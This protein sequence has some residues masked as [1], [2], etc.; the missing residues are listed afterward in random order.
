MKE[1][2][3][4]KLCLFAT[5]LSGIVSEYVLST[6]ASYFLGNTVFQWTMTVS[7][8]LFAM[9]LGSRVSKFFEKNLL[10]KFIYIEFLLSILS[11]LSAIFVYALS[12]Q[13]AD[14]GFF[15][16]FLS[17][18]IGLLIGLEIPLVVRL[19]ENFE[20]LR[21]NIAAVMEKDYYGSL[22]GG[23]FF[24]FIGLP[25][26][27]L[28]YTPFILGFIN[29]FVAIILLTKVSKKRISSPK[30]LY[31][32]ATGT[33]LIIMF[34]LFY[35]ENIVLFGEQAR[36]KDK[37]V[38]SKQTKYQKIVITEWK[39]DHWLFINGNQQLSSFDEFMYHEP[40]VHLPMSLLKEKKHVLIL[41]GG[42]GCAARELLK[43]EE[44]ESITLVDL[45]P[46]MTRLANENEIL[47]SMNNGALKSSKVEII[48]QDAFKFLNNTK[49]F[50]DLI[51]IDLPDP[52]T[53][54]L[55][56]LYSQEFYSLCNRQLRPHGLMITQAGSPYYASKAYLTINKTIE[57]SNFTTLKLHNHIIT[58]G[59]WGFILAS[60]VERNLKEELLNKNFTSLDLKWLNNESIKLMTSF[61]KNIIE[62]DSNEIMV[63]RFDNLILSKYYNKGNWDLY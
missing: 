1:S 2:K 32:S 6:L 26:I 21:L 13:T 16:Y 11:A 50:Y 52:K 38:Y 5:G 35:A 7:I 58:M 59:E 44:L 54:D 36:Y 4:L 43:Y 34:A 57:S 31:I 22:L 18:S 53:I 60:K 9:G 8:M 56:R 63:N 37:I 14:L 15:I 39:N 10:E 28:T 24:A 49:E 45:D 48:N 41:G 62:I 33:F 29:F 40:L 30:K 23:V 61:G 25:I 46:E 17:I 27:G 51:I 3:I 47:L 55:A 20:E 42:D 12:S 19:N